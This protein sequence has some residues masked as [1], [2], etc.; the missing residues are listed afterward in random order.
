MGNS[1]ISH[2]RH[3]PKKDCWWLVVGGE[4]KAAERGEYMSAPRRKQLV[5]RDEWEI[6]CEK[7]KEDFS[8]L[9]SFRS[10][11]VV[12]AMSQTNRSRHLWLHLQ[13][14]SFTN[15]LKLKFKKNVKREWLA[16]CN[17]KLLSQNVLSVNDGAESSPASFLYG[18][19]VIT[20][21][22]APAVNVFVYLC[23]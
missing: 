22:T 11:D 2:G 5:D 19:G 14:A 3:I 18:R 13:I 10:R 21:V 20:L 12:V 17:L 1:S 7:N 15:L 23:R 9:F 8:S 16:A 6:K 4:R